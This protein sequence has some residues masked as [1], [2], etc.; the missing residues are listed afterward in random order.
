MNK[1]QKENLSIL[2]K[3]AAWFVIIASLL[4]MAC[5]GMRCMMHGCKEREECKMERKHRGG[6]CERGEEKCKMPVGNSYTINTENCWVTGNEVEKRA[7]C[8]EGDDDDSKCCEKKEEQ[9]CKIKKDSVV[10]LKKGK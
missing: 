10:T 9:E 6:E 5:C 4:N 2:F 7:E 8:E 1:T 3:I